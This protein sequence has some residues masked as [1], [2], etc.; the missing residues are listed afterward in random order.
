MVLVSIEMHT[1]NVVQNKLH[2]QVHYTKNLRK[3]IN[4]T[5]RVCMPLLKLQIVPFGTLMGPQRGSRRDIT[6]MFI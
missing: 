1:S 6:R 2:L 4:F 3:L 5:I